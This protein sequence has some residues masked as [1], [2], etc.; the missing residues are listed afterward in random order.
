VPAK[1][2]GWFFQNPGVQPSS[3]G[4]GVVEGVG[5]VV[6][7]D[8]E[9]G[10][11]VVSDVVVSDVVI[12]DVVV[13]VDDD[14]EVADAVGVSVDVDVPVAPAATAPPTSA[15]TVSRPAPANNDG[16]PSTVAQPRFRCI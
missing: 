6:V 14:S 4:G 1:A 15:A 9:V 12:S 5:G 11:A 7:S 3:P 13:S 16:T 2:A 8:D 10:G